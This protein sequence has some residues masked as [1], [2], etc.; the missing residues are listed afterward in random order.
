MSVHRLSCEM[1]T[2]LPSSSAVSSVVDPLGLVRRVTYLRSSSSILSW[3]AGMVQTRTRSWRAVMVQKEMI[4]MLKL[5]VRLAPNAASVVMKLG[6]MPRASEMTRFAAVSVAPRISGGL[7]LMR[8][9]RTL[10]L[11]RLATL[12]PRNAYRHGS[13]PAWWNSQ[14]MSASMG[15]MPRRVETAMKT[16][17]RRRSMALVTCPRYPPPMLPTAHPSPKTATRVVAACTLSPRSWER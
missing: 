3:S 4:R 2:R 7:T 5:C 8:I 9:G 15:R 12:P 16:G 11:G 14:L 1:V 17:M 13:S 10:T 6:P